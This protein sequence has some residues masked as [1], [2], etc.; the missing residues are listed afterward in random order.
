MGQ[1]AVEVTVQFVAQRF[2]AEERPPVFGGED[3]VH[4]N[5]GE[6]LRHDGIMRDAA[7]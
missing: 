7:I 1:D 6:G 2:V 3:R 5:F 4:Q